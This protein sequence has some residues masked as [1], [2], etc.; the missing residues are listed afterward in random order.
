MV[1]PQKNFQLKQTFLNEN[2]KLLGLAREA[3]YR[4]KIKINQFSAAV[5]SLC[6]KFLVMMQVM[7]E[8]C[9]I[10]RQK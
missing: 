7:T 4:K 5:C 3:T 10:Q 6:S 1:L 9:S 2:G 8:K